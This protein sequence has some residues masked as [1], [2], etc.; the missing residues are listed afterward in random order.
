MFL[1]NILKLL[2]VTSI[3]FLA[4][5]GVF[6][7]SNGVWHSAE[8][9]RPGVFGSDESTIGFIFG[10]GLTVLG[11]SILDSV[12]VNSFFSGNG[13]DIVFNDKVQFNSGL[14]LV[15]GI[16][17]DSILVS[18]GV[19]S[20]L[21]SPYSGSNITL[22]GEVIINGKAQFKTGIENVGELSS[23]VVSASSGINSNLISPYLGTNITVNGVVTFGD[24]VT[25]SDDVT[26][27][28][29]FNCAGCIDEANLLQNQIDDSEI[30]DN[31]LSALSLAPNSVGSSEI[32]TNSVGNSEIRNTEPIT[33]SVLTISN[34]IE[35]NGNLVIVLK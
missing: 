35:S 5:V 20:N 23:D 4:V 9:I 1:K 28:G 21:I 14:E 24:E 11:S 6:A 7:E 3:I 30:Q 13:T 26:V 25:F 33:L 27:D 32:S 17:T 16:S 19:N 18:G 31:S 8:D 15:G 29:N 22:G 2:S 34:R 12:Y 10:S